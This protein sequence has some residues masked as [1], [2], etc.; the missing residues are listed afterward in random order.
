MKF[1]YLKINLFCLLIPLLFSFHPRLKFHKTWYAF[2]PAVFITAIYFILW[3][4]YFTDHG[5]WGFN[6][7][8]VT[9]LTIINLPVEEMLFFFCIPYACVFTFHCLQVILKATLPESTESKLTIAL[10]VLLFITGI[11]YYRKIYTACTFISLAFLLAFLKYY[12]Q[13]KWLGKFYIVYTMLL[14]P[15]LIV[16]GLLTGS[17]LEKPV[18]WYNADAIIGTRIGTIP[19]EDIFY[20]ME[21][22]LM[23]IMIYL[24]LIH[25]NEVKKTATIPN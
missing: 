22:I 16:N 13:V 12:L 21:L 20:G 9:G 7:E 19:F 24:H 4:I 2:F 8:Y 18:V 14:L 23:N 1:L 11:I 5:V 3:D 15:F 10:V 25:R 17:F 6:E